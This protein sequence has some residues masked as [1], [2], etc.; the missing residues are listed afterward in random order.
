MGPGEFPGRDSGSLHAGEISLARGGGGVF[1]EDRKIDVRGC[2][3]RRLLSSRRDRSKSRIRPPA[4]LVRK[5]G[6]FVEPVIGE[7]F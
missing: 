3:L 2:S 5:R 7:G 4:S 6:A 1:D